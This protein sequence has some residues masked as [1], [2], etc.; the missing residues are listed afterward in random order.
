MK[1]EEAIECQQLVAKLRSE[2]DRAEGAL[3]ECMTRLKSKWSCSTLDEARLLL[4]KKKKELKELE[5]K[6]IAAKKEFEEFIKT[7]QAMK[8]GSE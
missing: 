1:V 5:K 6:A 2:R 7:W 8:D 4:V 3:Q